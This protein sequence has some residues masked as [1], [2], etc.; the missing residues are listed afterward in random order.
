M[1]KP[2]TRLSLIHNRKR[3]I[4]LPKKL[5]IHIHKIMN[6]HCYGNGSNTIT[7]NN[8]N[9]FNK[10]D[11]SD[12]NSSSEDDTITIK[13]TLESLTDGKFINEGKRYAEI[14]SN[15]MDNNDTITVNLDRFVILKEAIKEAEL[16][17]NKEKTLQD[18]NH[19]MISMMYCSTIVSDDTLKRTCM[20]GN[21]IQC[22]FT[23][24]LC[25]IL[26][27]CGPMMV[28]NECL[29][30]DDLNVIPKDKRRKEIERVLSQQCQY[31]KK[32]NPQLIQN[33]IISKYSRHVIYANEMLHYQELLRLGLTEKKISKKNKK[34]EEEQFLAIDSYLP[35]ERSAI[36]SQNGL[37]TNKDLFRN[38]PKGR[39][40]L[41][42]Q[43]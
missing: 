2:L 17:L 34:A 7:N 16:V 12:S 24:Q 41:K 4:I 14:L 26:N 37:N 5:I 1:N 42:K 18:A 10:L 36:T 19:I 23:C 6:I 30:I 43:K 32:N 40:E 3:K 28:C 35:D 8:N 29:Q 20:C 33:L 15:H 27:M 9:S 31:S 21:Q 11:N 13:R 25:T 22:T 38:L 39:Q